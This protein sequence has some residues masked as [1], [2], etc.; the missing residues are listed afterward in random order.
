LR[1][2]RAIPPLPLHSVPL[3]HVIGRSVN[4]TFTN[5]TF[6]IDVGRYIGMLNR[7][8]NGV[9]DTSITLKNFKMGREYLSQQFSHYSVYNEVLRYVIYSI[10]HLGAYCRT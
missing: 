10:P 2:G 5:K 9:N 3:W 7:K 6:D 8:E 1:I 4:Y